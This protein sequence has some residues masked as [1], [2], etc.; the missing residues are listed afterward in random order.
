MSDKAR[1]TFQRSSQTRYIHLLVHSFALLMGKHTLWIP[2]VFPSPLGPKN[3][4]RAPPIRA[5]K[6][7]PSLG[8]QHLRVNLTP[9]WY[10]KNTVNHRSSLNAHEFIYSRRNHM[11]CSYI[12][13]SWVNLWN[14]LIKC[15]T[16]R[17]QN[18]TLGFM[19]YPN[20]CALFQ[21]V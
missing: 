17:G 9:P 6:I 13:A 15:T 1:P 11:H 21:N 19:A 8:P 3:Y 2:L 4:P 16:W 20:F 12:F 18:S 7:H 10:G 14:C 5:Q